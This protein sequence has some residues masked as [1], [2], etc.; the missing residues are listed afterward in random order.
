MFGLW[1]LCHGAGVPLGAPWFSG[2]GVRKCRADRRCGQRTEDRV[3]RFSRPRQGRSGCAHQPGYQE[4]GRDAARSSARVLRGKPHSM[5]FEE[6]RP[7]FGDVRQRIAGRATRR[8][9]ISGGDGIGSD[10]RR[11]SGQTWEALYNRAAPTTA[12]RIALG[13]AVVSAWKSASDQSAEFEAAQNS[14]MLSSITVGMPRT[15]VYS[16]LKSH[17]LIP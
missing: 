15:H 10:G 4:S 17:G 9:R 11:Y 6:R 12:A 5:G 1:T 16:A 14:W 2:S 8:G 13:K 7:G 3:R